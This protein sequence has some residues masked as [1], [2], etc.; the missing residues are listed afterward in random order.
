[1]ELIEP[2]QVAVQPNPADHSARLSIRTSERGVAVVEL[3]NA[4]GMLVSRH[5]AELDGTGTSGTLQLEELPSGLYNMVVRT[6]EQ[7]A[8]THVVKR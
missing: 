7:F 2:L 8:Y 4:V 6:P 1:V 5:H 3:Y